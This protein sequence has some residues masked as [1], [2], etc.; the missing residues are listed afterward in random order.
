MHKYNTLYKRSNK[1]YGSFKL[2]IIIFATINFGNQLVYI[3]APMLS[4]NHPNRNGRGPFGK[5]D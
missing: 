5:E 2:G 4:I 3:R 1:I